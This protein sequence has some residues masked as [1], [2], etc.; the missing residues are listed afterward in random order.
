MIRRSLAAA[1][2]LC[3]SRVSTAADPGDAIEA[4]RLSARGRL[5]RPGCRMV[6]SSYTDSSGRTL[7]DNLRA[8]DMKPEVFLDG[9]RFQPAAPD[10]RP[11]AEPTNVF[12]TTPGTRV[13]FV[14]GGRFDAL[15]AAQPRL[16]T[17]LVLH[18]MLHSLGLGENPPSP[19]QITARVMDWCR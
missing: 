10:A 13:V 8:L 1:L 3:A 5:M 7:N 17:A 14:C 9:L 12:F 11:C 2:L 4:A 15:H 16:T 18:E 19:A 6:L